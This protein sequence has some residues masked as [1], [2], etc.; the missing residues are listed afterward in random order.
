MFAPFFS[1]D[2][3][4]VISET[5]TFAPNVE[6]NGLFLAAIC[7]F[8]SVFCA[9]IFGLACICICVLFIFVFM[10]VYVFVFAFVLI[11]TNCLS[12]LFACVCCETWIAVSNGN[13]WGL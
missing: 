2:S 6:G 10:L 9:S 7:C 4:W 12:E 1:Q 5:I 11:S 3:L 8:A 13:K